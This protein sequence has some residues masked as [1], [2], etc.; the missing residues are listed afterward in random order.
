MEEKKERSQDYRKGQQ[1]AVLYCLLAFYIGFM[2]YSILKNRLMG[3]T[4]ISFPLAA[5][6]SA[7]F[8]AGAGGIIWYAA[9]LIRNSRRQADKDLEK[10]ERK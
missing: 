3:E 7:L 2:G 6:I 5:A 1:K 10:E 4:A 8:I 9:K